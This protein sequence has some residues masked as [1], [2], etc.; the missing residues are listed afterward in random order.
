[1]M[2]RPAAGGAAALVGSG[3]AHATLRL[4]TGHGLPWRLHRRRG[5][6]QEP[7]PAGAAEA[8]GGRWGGGGPPHLVEGKGCAAAILV[9]SLRGGASHAS[10]PPR[11]PPAA[12]VYSIDERAKIRKSH[13]NPSV[14]RLYQARRAR[15]A[16]PLLH[17]PHLV[18]EAA[19]PCQTPGRCC[20]HPLALAGVPGRAQR[21]PGPRAAA[22]HLH[23]QEPLQPARLRHLGAPAGAGAPPPAAGAEPP[24]IRPAGSGAGSQCRVFLRCTSACFLSHLAQISM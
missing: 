7:R 1:M 13:E 4:P 16:R 6:A 10:A 14:Q 17:R 8:H 15:R 24:L 19:P 21:A 9:R 3:P 22:H 23:R 12:P 2:L 20:C 18:H 5:P 11:A